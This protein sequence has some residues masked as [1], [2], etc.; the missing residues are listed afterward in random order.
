MEPQKNVL[1]V[2]TSIVISA[3]IIVGALILKSDSSEQV[4]RSGREVET[5]IYQEEVSVTLPLA[6][7]DIGQKLVAVG[8]LDRDAF[9]ALYDGWDKEEARRLI[10]TS[11]TSIVVNKANAGIVLNLLWAVG[12]SNKSSILEKGEMSDPRYGGADRFASTGGWSIASGN[13]MDHY[14]RHLFMKLTSEQEGLVNRVSANMYRPCCNNSTHF[15]DCNHGMAMLG[16]LEIM[17]SSGSSE[18]ELYEAGLV[19]N[20][21]WFPSQYEMVDRYVTQEDIN[22]VDAKLLLSASMISSSGF[23]KI[24]QAVR[25]P[26]AERGAGGGGCSI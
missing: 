18:S 15:P 9:L 21:L 1:T 12:L 13:P 4:S 7:G 3:V 5:A 8:A 17:A 22:N 25:T 6:W 26:P 2:P 14:S 19:L 16:L 10:D 23:Q 11:P 24:A 20:R